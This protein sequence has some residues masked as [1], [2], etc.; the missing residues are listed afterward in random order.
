MKGNRLNRVI[1]TAA[2][3]VA[4]ALLAV[5][6]TSAAPPRNPASDAP[7]VSSLAPLMQKEIHWGMTHD[8]VTEAFN[9]PDGIID[10][11]FAPK[12]GKMQPG[13]EMQELEADK[14]NRKVNF[15]R[16]LTQFL[17]SPTGYDLTPLKEEYTYRNSE[18]IQRIFRDGKTR[19][20]FYI[21]DHLWKIYDEVPLKADG[22][23]GGSFKD[24]VT[25]LAGLLTVPGRVRAPD[26]QNGL[27]RTTVDW[28][29]AMNH[30]RC[31]DRSSERLVGVVMEDKRTLANLG[32]LRANRPVDPFA[33]DPAIA[34]V[35]RGGVSDPNAARAR[36]D[37]D[38]GAPSKG[39]R[40]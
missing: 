1:V 36:G 38:A 18:A 40:H 26:A 31:V 19:Y 33:I 13:V 11:D 14:E 15:A 25:K 32:T 8:E 17:D 22:P 21:N 24:A 5:S 2:G 29:D 3:L 30:L 23:L 16:S 9:A 34:A 39:K 28:Q 27:E 35:T 7:V 12:L 6:V 10:R 37:A 20:F 4:G